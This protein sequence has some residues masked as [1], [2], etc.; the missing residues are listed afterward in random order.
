MFSALTFNRVLLQHIITGFVAY[1]C[2]K[3]DVL[4]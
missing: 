3:G 2:N 4:L 1:S